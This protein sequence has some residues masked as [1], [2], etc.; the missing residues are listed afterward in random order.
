MLLHT[1]STD[2]SPHLLFSVI[3]LL[4][5]NLVDSKAQKR[6]EHHGE[7]SAVCP[8]QAATGPIQIILCLKR[9]LTV[10]LSPESSVSRERRPLAAGGCCSDVLPE[11]SP[12]APAHVQQFCCASSAR[13]SARA[14]SGNEGQPGMDRRGQWV[15]STGSYKQ[16]QTTPERCHAQNCPVFVFLRL[17]SNG[18]TTK[19]PLQWG[20]VTS[21]AGTCVRVGELLPKTSRPRRGKPQADKQH[22]KDS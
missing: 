15:H 22:V 13:N 6:T 11:P 2:L 18:H 8:K 4:K 1:S 7:L 16:Q 12:P 3:H 17:D 9:I 21:S 20:C 10:F 19:A 14:A 5:D